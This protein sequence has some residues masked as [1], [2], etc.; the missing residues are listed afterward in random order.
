MRMSRIS[1]PVPRI[2]PAEIHDLLRPVFDALSTTPHFHKPKEV[3]CLTRAKRSGDT[4]S[5]RST[6]NPESRE[7]LGAGYGQVRD[8]QLSADFNVIGFAAPFVVVVRNSDGVKGSLEF[9]HHPRFYYD[10]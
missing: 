6:P 9:Q 8:T 5:P 2:S 4:S 7:S 1:S 10:F 3:T